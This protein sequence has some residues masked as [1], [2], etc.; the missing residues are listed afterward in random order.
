MQIQ[1]RPAKSFNKPHEHDAPYTLHVVFIS[2]SKYRRFN[3]KHVY[4][5]ACGV[6]DDLFVD[7]TQHDPPTGAALFS[8]EFQD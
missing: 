7:Q 8:E 3:L 5:C 2:Q 1:N 6:D 4:S